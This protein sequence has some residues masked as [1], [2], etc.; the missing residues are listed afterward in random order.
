M[1]KIHSL[2][3]PRLKEPEQHLLLYTY[4][5]LRIIFHHH[6][7]IPETQDQYHRL[8]PLR[9]FILFQLHFH[10]LITLAHILSIWKT[11]P[12][13]FTVSIEVLNLVR[14]LLPPLKSSKIQGLSIVYH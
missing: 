14:L 7:L 5:N 8:P 9:H 3:I 4:L 10:F 12:L 13:N 1:P 11:V 2:A 6:N